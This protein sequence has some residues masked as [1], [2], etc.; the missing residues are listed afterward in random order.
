MTEQS[1]DWLPT[2]HGS[3]ISFEIL[4]SRKVRN[5]VLSVYV[6]SLMLIFVSWLSLW[7]RTTAFTCNIIEVMLGT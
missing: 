5:S 1:L 6:P 7:V 3:A 4:L 2:G